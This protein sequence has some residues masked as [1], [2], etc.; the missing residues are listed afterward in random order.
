M[1][2]MRESASSRAGVASEVDAALRE[3]RHAADHGDHQPVS[4]GRGVL[5]GE[6]AQHGALERVAVLEARDAVVRERG[7]H[8]RQELLA[9]PGAARAQAAH[10]HAQPRVVRGAEV[11]RDRRTRRADQQL[12]DVGEGAQLAAD[13]GQL[14]R[15][16]PPR[17]RPGAARAS[18]ETRR[19]TRSVFT[20]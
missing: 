2:A 15:A 14:R 3:G 18:S 16:A 10:E 8:Q 6:Q 7:A 17:A 13:A 19:S 4:H 5:G 1:P 11:A 9:D 20:S 12:L